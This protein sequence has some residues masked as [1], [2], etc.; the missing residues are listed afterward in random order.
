[1][2]KIN[3]K[4][5]YK[6]KQI[7]PIEITNPLGNAPRVSSTAALC[8]KLARGNILVHLHIFHLQKHSFDIYKLLDMLVL[9]TKQKIIIF[10]TSKE[11]KR[12]LHYSDQIDRNFVTI[13]PDSCHY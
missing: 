4:L 5:E 12:M 13:E 8:T 10:S 7:K 1:L 3:P 6:R 11:G 2:V 9:K